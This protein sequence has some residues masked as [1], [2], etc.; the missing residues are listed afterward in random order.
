[1]GKRNQEKKFLIKGLRPDLLII[2]VAFIIL[3]PRGELKAQWIELQISPAAISFTATDPDLQPV[4][5]ASSQ[6][7]ISIRLPQSR[8]WALYVMA[9]GNLVSSEGNVIPITKISWQAAPKPP[10]NDGAFVA[11]QNILLGSG[12]GRFFNG[13]LTFYFQ[14]SWDYLPGTYT[15]VIIFTASQI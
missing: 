9:Q 11:G 14:D 1:M 10:L 6:V 4:V 7:N 8:K 13:T 12:I 15:Q 5:Q 2:A 3:M